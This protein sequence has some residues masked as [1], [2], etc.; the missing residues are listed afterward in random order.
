LRNQDITSLYIASKGCKQALSSYGSAAF[1]LWRQ[2][3]DSVE[4]APHL[5]DTGCAPAGITP[6]PGVTLNSAGESGV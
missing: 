3:G 1:N 6:V 5:G 2:C 4:T